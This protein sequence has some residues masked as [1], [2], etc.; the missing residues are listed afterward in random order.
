MVKRNSKKLSTREIY[1]ENK[2]YL[3][4][5]LSSSVISHR[6]LGWYSP[7]DWLGKQP[8]LAVYKGKKILAALACPP[9]P[10]QIAW[11][12]LFT[13]SSSLSPEKAWQLMWP[14]ARKK[15]EQD[16]TTNTI[17][18]IAIQKWLWDLLG[19]SG[20][21]QTYRITSLS[22]GP[23]YPDLPDS[24][25]GIN[26]RDMQSGDILAVQKVDQA[27]FAPLWHNSLDTFEHAHKIAAIATVAEIDGQIA[28][29]QISTEDVWGG[30]LARL[31]ISPQY[32][33]KGIA[34]ALVHDLLEKFKEQGCSQ[35]TVNTQTQNKPSLK[36]YKKFGF[37]QDRATYPVYQLKL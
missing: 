19:E 8:Y 35:V 14:L 21:S 25:P 34:T 23:P 20:F 11:I 3:I 4:N 32:Q 5:L 2:E 33:R 27:A 17:A 9:N 10:P 30:H 12:R 26:I 24:Q 18:I 28:G 16:G 13:V 22:W 1:L 37:Q 15:L 6:H 36:L 31:A 29:Y 7:I